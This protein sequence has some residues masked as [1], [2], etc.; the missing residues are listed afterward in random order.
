[1][2]LQRGNFT[3]ASWLGW[4]NFGMFRHPAGAVCSYS[5]GLPARGTPQIEVNPT[6][7]HDR[8]CH[9]VL[10][11]SCQCTQRFGN[12][13]YP[14]LL[15]SIFAEIKFT[16]NRDPEI[17]KNEQVKKYTVNVISVHKTLH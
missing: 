6:K 5:A 11:L 8:N 17:S 10:N 15:Q 3:C 13:D 12:W 9:P 2:I 14:H 7:V 16:A 4:L 1:M